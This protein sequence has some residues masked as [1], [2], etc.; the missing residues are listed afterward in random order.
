MGLGARKKSGK[1]VP[2]FSTV[3]SASD[4]CQEVLLLSAVQS[5]GSMAW[6]GEGMCV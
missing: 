3:L 5:R 1:V 4:E 6:C 2:D